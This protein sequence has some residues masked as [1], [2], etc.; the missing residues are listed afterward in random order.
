MLQDVRRGRKSEINHINGKFLELGDQLG[1]DVP[2]MRTVVDIV[3]KL[4]NNELSIDNSW[5]NLHYFDIPKL[6]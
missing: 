1:I 5:D 6:P 4:E 2:F 3:T